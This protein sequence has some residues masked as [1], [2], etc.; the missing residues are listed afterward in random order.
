MK[1]GAE[2]AISSCDKFGPVNLNLSTSKSRHKD[3]SKDSS[4]LFAVKD[5]VQAQKKQAEDA[6][7]QKKEKKEK[8]EKREQRRDAPLASGLTAED[9]EEEESEKRVSARLHNSGHVL[10][11]FVPAGAI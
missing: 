7:A 8:R 5:A 10:H 3:Q 2:A 11:D 4:V 9:A 6:A 1:Q